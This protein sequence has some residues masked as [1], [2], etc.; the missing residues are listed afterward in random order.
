LYIDGGEKGSGENKFDLKEQGIKQREK[1][2]EN[3]NKNNP[4]KSK[5]V[6]ISLSKQHYLTVA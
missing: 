6:F 3:E 5:V 2:K 4:S 1:E